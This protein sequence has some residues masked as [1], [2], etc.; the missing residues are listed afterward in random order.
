MSETKNSPKELIV[1]LGYSLLVGILWLTAFFVEGG[2]TLEEELTKSAFY[3]PLFIWGFFGIFGLIILKLIFNDHPLFAG[4]NIHEP[5]EAVLGRWSFFTNIWNIIW[6]SIVL[7]S[8]MGV[9]GVKSNLFFAQTPISQQITSTG[10]ILLSAFP[11]SGA[12]T[13][14][15]LF[16][17][18]FLKIIINGL[19]M[20]FDF[21][22]ATKNVL[23]YFFIPVIISA[24][25]I[26]LHILRYGES[27]LSI[28]SV[29]LFG[30]TGAILTLLSGSVIVWL[31]A[32]DLNNV[33][34]TMQKLFE[35]DTIMFGTIIGIVLITIIGIVTRGKAEDE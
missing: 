13:L 19:Q 23:T 6:T 5:E 9:I 11:A 1:Y 2:A 30:F 22:D 35:A 29:A 33:Y 27:Q 18:F 3:S 26:L 17:L 14:F 7:F 32:H 31:I 10:K 25:W 20:K 15:F 28:I 4:V 16:L 8:I 12:E 34:F 24:G 21:S